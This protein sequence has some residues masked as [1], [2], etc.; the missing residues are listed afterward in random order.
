V[1]QS[2]H[3][4][5]AIG[6]ELPPNTGC[7][8]YVT[9]A[10]RTKTF[11]SVGKLLWVNVAGFVVDVAITTK[12]FRRL[13]KSEPCALLENRRRERFYDYLWQ[14][15][16]CNELFDRVG[17]K[18][19]QK[20]FPLSPWKCWRKRSAETVAILGGIRTKLEKLRRDSLVHSVRESMHASSS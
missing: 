20:K 4:A 7:F 18:Q 2:N 6:E 13:K 16:S 14:F 1:D 9:E 8:C 15:V 12:N 11:Q 10:R 19:Y 5:T 17:K 3:K